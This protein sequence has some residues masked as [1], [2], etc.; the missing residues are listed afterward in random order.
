VSER[1]NKVNISDRSARI[2]EE[3]YIFVKNSHT[4]VLVHVHCTSSLE[5]RGR[6]SKLGKKPKDLLSSHPSQILS[7]LEG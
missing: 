2:Y 7:F 5:K 6:I 1:E 3:P 4:D